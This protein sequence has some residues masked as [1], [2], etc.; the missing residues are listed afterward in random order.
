MI[1]S[2]TDTPIDLTGKLLVAMPGMGDP[3]F[4]KS[5]IL[6]CAHSADGAMGLIVNKPAEKVSF[7]DLLKQLGIDTDSP[8]S[9]PAICFGGPVEHGRGFVL[10]S[11]DYGAPESTMEV[12]GGFGMTATLDILEDIASGTGPERAILA[13]GYSGWAPGQLEEEIGQNGWLTCDASTDL[14][15]SQ[16]NPAKW[17]AALNSLGIDALALSATAG[18]A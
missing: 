2:D 12:P 10:H 1:M 16:E 11:M 13:L 8:S 3:R 6:I 4:E 5:V 17:T 9:G 18:R 14:V 15:F 7:A